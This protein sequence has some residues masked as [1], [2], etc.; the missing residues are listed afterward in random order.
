M[1]KSRSSKP[2]VPLADLILEMQSWINSCLD[3]SAD[4]L[5]ERV[6]KTCH[7]IGARSVRSEPG[8]PALT[9]RLLAIPA[10]IQACPSYLQEAFARDQLTLLRKTIERYPVPEPGLVLAPERLTRKRTKTV[11]VDHELQGEWITTGV[12]YTT[13]VYGGVTTQRTLVEVWLVPVRAFDAEPA[14]PVLLS[15]V[16]NISLDA[17]AEPVRVPGERFIGTIGFNPSPGTDGA[18][19]LSSAAIT[20][21]TAAP[22]PSATIATVDK[23]FRGARIIDPTV[24]EICVTLDTAIVGQTGNLIVLGE[25]F[26]TGMVLPLFRQQLGIL[27]PLR[28]QELSRVTITWNGFYAILLSAST[29]AGWFFDKP[30]VSPYSSSYDVWPPLALPEAATRPPFEGAVTPIPSLEQYGLDRPYLPTHARLAFVHLHSMPFSPDNELPRLF[31]YV[32]HHVEVAGYRIHV[33][34]LMAPFADLREVGAAIVLRHPGIE[35][36]PLAWPSSWRW[37]VCRNEQE[38]NTLIHSLHE[39]RAQ[40]PVAGRN[41]VVRVLRE[42]KDRFGRDAVTAFRVNL[43]A[44]D[45]PALM[46]LT[47]YKGPQQ[48]A[49]SPEEEA[50]RL[51][52]VC[53]GT[54]LY[55]KRLGIARQMLQIIRTTQRIDLH[56]AASKINPASRLEHKLIDS[57]DGFGITALMDG[58]QAEDLDLQWI[59]REYPEALCAL[60]GAALRERNLA[61][62]TR[63]VRAQPDPDWPKNAL[64]AFPRRMPAPGFPEPILSSEERR[65]LVE[66]CFDPRGVI[67]GPQS[68]NL[69]S[70][71]SSLKPTFTPDFV[72]RLVSSSAFE[73]LK[74]RI[75]QRSQNGRRIPRPDSILFGLALYCGEVFEKE[76]SY[77]PLEQRRIST[78]FF[79]LLRTLT[80]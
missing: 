25:R 44:D 22:A 17:Y 2:L 27:G 57:F 74:D 69:S 61:Q 49:F 5:V 38:G 13:L 16:Q 4:G 75:A 39:L 56:D 43:S 53:P 48:F 6:S 8:A 78:S 80:V 42:R 64:F 59:G 28:D 50:Y 76:L 26:G 54:D 40:D 32:P 52:Q 11:P 29:P 60:A 67:L 21:G 34:D 3:G 10:R 20:E 71:A 79:E 51:I 12:R 35:D 46:E 70:L 19:L 66:G 18:F 36:D 63:L 9:N 1:A 33:D 73:K 30:T 55:K 31:S 14:Q 58:D 45:L 77:L 41:E 47:H 7:V 68:P 72:R 15:E 37:H 23:Q 24:T 62:A 65:A